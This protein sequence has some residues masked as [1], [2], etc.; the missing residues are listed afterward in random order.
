VCG[1]RKVL[2]G[3]FVFYTATC[4]GTNAVCSERS[5][6]FGYDASEAHACRQQVYTD[7]VVGW[8]RG[9]WTRQ[10]SQSD[11]IPQVARWNGPD[12]MANLSDAGSPQG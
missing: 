12:R 11:S 1:A 7:W 3:T 10:R 9:G 5:S 6:V 8:G 4:S 2:I